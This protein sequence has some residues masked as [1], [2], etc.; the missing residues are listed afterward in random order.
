MATSFGEEKFCEVPLAKTPLPGYP[1][2]YV[3]VLI[4]IGLMVIPFKT[5]HSILF[6]QIFKYYTGEADSEGRRSR[7]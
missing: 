5:T 7:M 3:V 6:H 1:S 4:A 2:E